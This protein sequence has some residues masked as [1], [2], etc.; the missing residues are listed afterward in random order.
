MLGDQLGELELVEHRGHPRLGVG[1]LALGVGPV[2]HQQLHPLQRAATVR[3]H[4]G[5]IGQ[6]GEE[7]A[8]NG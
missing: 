4:P 1:E 3:E 2:L 5:R 6:G 8:E 7:L